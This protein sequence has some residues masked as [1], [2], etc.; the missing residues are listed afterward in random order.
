MLLLVGLHLRGN[1]VI[2]GGLGATEAFTVDKVAT[3]NDQGINHNQQEQFLVA[4]GLV[5]IGGGLHDGKWAGHS[6]YLL[7]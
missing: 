3:K 1:F 4:D 6:A 7:V 2:G 5:D